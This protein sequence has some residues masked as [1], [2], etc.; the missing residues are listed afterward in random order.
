MEA[1]AGLGIN[2]YHSWIV[3]I[4]S[5]LL[6][7]KDIATGSHARHGNQNAIDDKEYKKE[8]ETMQPLRQII[9]DA[10]AVFSIP[11]E[12]QHKNIEIIVWPLDMNH[13]SSCQSLKDVLAA[14]P[15]VGEDAEFMR[16]ADYG[17][18]DESWD[19]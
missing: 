19:I 6:H 11:E 17:R 13:D 5:V 9:H 4:Q 18:K 7:G 12:F 1:G 15:D 2:I 14:M 3:P 16:Q 8:C 10:P